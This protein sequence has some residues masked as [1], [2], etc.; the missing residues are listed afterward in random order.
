MTI[1]NCWRNKFS[2]YQ[3]LRQYSDGDPPDGDPPDGASN[4]GEVGKNRD[5][6]PISLGPTTGGVTSIIS[7]MD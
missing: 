6:R 1:R 5:C 3:T 4:G 2:V 7:T